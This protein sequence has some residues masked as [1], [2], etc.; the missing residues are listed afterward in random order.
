MITDW[1]KSFCEYAE[2][3]NTG[4]LFREWGGVWQLST[5]IGR[6]AGTKLRGQLTPPNLYLILVSGPGGGKSQIVNAIRPI[7]LRA[8]NISTIPKSVTRAGLQ[9][10]MQ[11]NLKPRLQP[12]GTQAPCHE[13]VALS[14]EMQGI[15][16]E[17]DI[18]HL[19]MY[20]ELYDPQQTYRARTRTHGTVDLQLPYCSIITGAQPAFLSLMIPEHAWGM[21]FMSRCI[22]VYDIQPTRTSAFDYE[23]VDHKLESE[24]ILH[25]KKVHRLHGW[26]QWEPAAKELY[27][28]WWV[29][30]GGPPV[31]VQK[32]LAMGYNARRERQFFKLSM[33]FSLSRTTDLTVTV[34]DAARALELLLRTEDRMKHVFSEMASTGAIAAYGDVVDSIRLRC[35]T[36]TRLPEADLIHMLMDRFQPSQI[37][38]MIENLLSSGVIAEAAGAVSGKGIR[39]FVPGP[40]MQA[41]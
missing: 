26:F 8:T 15:L 24:L 33:C 18:G 16:P 38:A 20:N 13:C 23:D 22:L 7:L 19:T 39:S 31:P 29:Q 21:G 25:L 17:H 10:Y 30:S 3:Y 12:D 41:L 27:H 32:R 1:I 34:E 9:D 14:E 28:Q 4:P 11:E 5:A 40:K 37:E 36:G 6:Q 35:A 2:P